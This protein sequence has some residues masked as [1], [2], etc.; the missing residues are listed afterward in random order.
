MNEIIDPKVYAFRTQLDEL[1]KDI[2][3][4]TILIDHD[5][6]AETV[7]SLRNRIHEPF[8][9]VIV[10]EVKAGKS[11]FI[12]ALLDTGREITKVA[13]QPMTD[14]IQQ[15]VYGP[16]EDMNTCIRQ[17]VF[18]E[19]LCKTTGFR[20]RQQILALFEG[21]DNGAFIMLWPAVNNRPVFFADMSF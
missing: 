12:N 3:H 2:H 7:S 16:V 18:G 15:I 21:Q 10:G 1:A 11:S 14:T 20:E 13:P 17:K 5:D 6:L 8:M 4:L 9:F 19:A